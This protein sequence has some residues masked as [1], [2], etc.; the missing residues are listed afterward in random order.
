LVTALKGKPFA[1]NY[2]MLE[3][4]K[5]RDAKS[6][7]W[8]LRSDEY[9]TPRRQLKWRKMQT[10]AWERQRMMLALM[11]SMNKHLCLIPPEKQ[12]KQTIIN[13]QRLNAINHL[14]TKPLSPIIPTNKIIDAVAKDNIEKPQQAVHKIV[15][16]NSLPERAT[17]EP[18]PDWQ[19]DDG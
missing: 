14:H 1:T 10:Y 3:T 19:G 16:V 4:N 7:T 6:M 13:N 11:N 8:N 9:Y 5:S 15:H 18:V 12:A 17:Q 2:W